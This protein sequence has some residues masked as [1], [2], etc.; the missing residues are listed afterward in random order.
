[1]WDGVAPG[2]GRSLGG[3]TFPGTCCRG[4]ASVGVPQLEQ[5]GDCERSK[6]GESVAAGQRHKRWRA[7]KY[8]GLNAEPVVV[9]G[10][11]QYVCYS[12]LG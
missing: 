6:I 3:S 9:G 10:K 5:G 8:W 1:M 4:A 12:Q 7:L 2:T 11:I